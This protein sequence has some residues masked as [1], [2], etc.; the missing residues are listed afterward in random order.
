MKDLFDKISSYNIFNYL[1][2]GVLFV[3]IARQYLGWNFV[4]ND[5][6]T[7]GFVYYFIGLIISRFGSIVI[8]PILK[9]TKFLQYA[10]YTKY[11]SAV[12]TDDKIEILLEVNNTYRTLATLVFLLFVLRG[13]KFLELKFSISDEFTIYFTGC[14]VLIMFLF[15]HRKQTSFI[16]KRVDK[17]STS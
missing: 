13:Y 1:L 4:Q 8:E 9:K 6:L 16:K 7:A 15:A 10:E 5:P 17:V 2:P 14:I 12:K 11:L 3:V